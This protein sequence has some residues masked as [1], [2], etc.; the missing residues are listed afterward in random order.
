MLNGAIRGRVGCRLSEL[1]QQKLL[2]ETEQRNFAR[3]KSQRRE[4]EREILLPDD[5]FICGV[6]VARHAQP[7]VKSGHR[8]RPRQGATS[9]LL[10]HLKALTQESATSSPRA[11][12]RCN[13]T[14]SSTFN[15]HANDVMS[16]AQ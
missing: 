4:A 1:K 10:I 11:S 13:R 8:S 7:R 14:R 3:L 12:E 6:P 15:F 5:V 16:I 9:V 2:R